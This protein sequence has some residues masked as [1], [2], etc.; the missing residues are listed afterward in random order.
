MR[1]RIISTQCRKLDVDRQSQSLIRLARRIGIGVEWAETT[2]MSW[3]VSHSR[4]D[5]PCSCINVERELNR[6]IVNPGKCHDFI[7]QR[8]TH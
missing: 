8:E 6:S 1:P 3:L 5:V 4:E 2:A 7:L